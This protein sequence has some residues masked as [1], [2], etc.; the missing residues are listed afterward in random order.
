MNVVGLITEYNPFH[1]G[2]CHHLN[3]A[4][5]ICQAD[6]VIVVMS[7]NFVQ[8][9]APAII[10]KYKR[11]RMA[12]E[13]GADLVLELPAPFA[14]GSAEIF[15]EAAVSL[16][17]SLG[18]VNS[19]CFGSEHASLPLLKLPAHI[20]L[21]EPEHY[22]K[23]LQNSLQKGNNY[24]K[25]RTEALLSYIKDSKD[26]G[27]TACKWQEILSSPNN[28]LGIEYLKA[29][30]RL[31]SNITPIAIP[32]I[33][34]DYHE[35]TITDRISSATAIRRQLETNP[36]WK[37]IQSAVPEH[38]FSILKTEYQKSFPIYP[39][40]FSG[41]FNYCLNTETNFSSYAELSNELAARLKKRLPACRTLEQWCDELKTKAY[42]RTR[43]SR[44][45]LHMILQITKED[46]E[47]WKHSHYCLYG[48]ILG[49]RKNS[50]SLLSEIKRHSQVPILTK[51]ADAPALL[52]EAGNQLLAKELQ[53]SHIYR[54]IV[55]EKF[56]TL[57]PDEYRAGIQKV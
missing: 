34:A 39:D 49:F 44:G 5:C 57:L 12:L 33:T 53:A 43:I 1:N 4:R 3:E 40:D 47:L 42:T 29:L 38:V 22:R 26:V 20:A 25:A 24:A 10:D 2:H 7:G 13:A 51:I 21:K 28:I 45:L 50:F 9:G 14:S 54:Q 15:A 35:E 11:C 55:W 37:L 36:E 52:T 18:V 16:L 46:M 19:L 31:N 32:R 30:Y 56:C 27:L 23:V 17:D 48:R 41:L 6:F 8:R